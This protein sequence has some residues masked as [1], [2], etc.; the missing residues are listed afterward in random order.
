MPRASEAG[1]DS[2]LLHPTVLNGEGIRQRVPS[3]FLQ[4]SCPGAAIER[5]GVLVQPP[6]KRGKLVLTD[7]DLVLGPS[8]SPPDIAALIEGDVVALGQPQPPVRQLVR[9]FQTRR[10]VEAV[11]PGLLRFSHLS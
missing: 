3:L 10:H 1:V 9:Q 11:E 8:E 5:F 7:V 4:E 2:E 6:A